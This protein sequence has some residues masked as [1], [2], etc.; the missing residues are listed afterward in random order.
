MIPF[1][2]PTA[3]VELARAWRFDP[4]KGVPYASMTKQERAKL[5]EARKRE[6]LGWSSIELDCTPEQVL[7]FETADW[8]RPG[9]VPFAGN[10]FGD[11]YCWYPRWKEPEATEPPIVFFVHDELE[12]RL[13]ARTFSELLCRCMLQH[14]A[15]SDAELELFGDHW[16]IV[17][18]WLAP[19]ERER[20]SGIAGA[21]S[22]VACESADAEIAKDVGVR[23][24]L[25]AMQPV[26]YAEQHFEDRAILL[27][28]Y[29]R[30]VAFYRE[31]VVDE[32]HEELRAKLDETTSHRDR[33]A[34]LVGSKRRPRT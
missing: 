6:V 19:R 18:P 16:A 27:R 3:F 22:R 15:S 4:W 34:R 31:L 30:S 20:M 10:G 28:A 23:T 33:V 9:L 32:G 25:G 5:W 12:S 26:K 29:E 21:P 1:E 17:E 24:L 2:L 14:Y 7:A 13:F 8:L 11:H